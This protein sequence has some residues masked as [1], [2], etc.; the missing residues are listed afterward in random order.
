MFLILGFHKNDL[1]GA[2]TRSSRL[3]QTFRGHSLVLVS[4]VDCTSIACSSD[5]SIASGK[6]L[7]GVLDLFADGGLGVIRGS[8]CLRGL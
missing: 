3:L 7:V 4:D 1:R 2:A 6:D 8:C 5:R